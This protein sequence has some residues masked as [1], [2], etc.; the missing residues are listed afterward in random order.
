MFRTALPVNRKERYYTGTV[1]PM[2]IASDG[3]AHLDRFLALCGLDDLRFVENNR[4]GLQRLQFFTEYSF[5]ESVFTDADHARFAAAPSDND[6]PD[7]VLVGDDWIL[8]VE[9]KMFHTPNA[10]ALNLQLRRQRIVLDYLTSILGIAADRACHVFLLPEGLA[11]DGL[12]APVVTWEQVLDAYRVVGPRYWVAVLAAALDR[13]DELKSRGPEFGQFRDATMTGADIVAA[14]E[15]GALA[16][17][18][19]GRNRGI[20][21]PDLA[22]DL[23]DGSWRTRHYEVRLE[24][25]TSRNWFPI[26]VFIER[27]RD[28]PMT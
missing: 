18:Y 5:A 12:D 20:D 2:L 24:A 11:S 3:F 14:H 28:S 9:A 21:G 16:Y 13:Y 8:A 17:T 23:A 22:G 7:L 4:E 1:L 10:Q 19:M 6:T 25:L 15:A 26:S 27:T